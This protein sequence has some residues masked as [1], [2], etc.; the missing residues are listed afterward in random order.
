MRKAFFILAI[1]VSFSFAKAGQEIEV[2]I[3]IGIGSAFFW[4][5]GVVEREIHTGGQLA[6][7]A[8]L[9]PKIFN[10]ARLRA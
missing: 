3:N 7:Y 5:P 2:P 6:L 9:T 1:F 10:H 8:V 4:I